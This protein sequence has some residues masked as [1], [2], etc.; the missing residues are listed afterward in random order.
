MKPQSCSFWLRKSGVPLF[1]WCQRRQRLPPTSLK[2]RHS[3]SCDGCHKTAAQTTSCSENG[4]DDPWFMSPVLLPLSYEA[5]KLQLLATEIWC[6]TVYVVPEETAF[7]TYKPRARVEIRHSFSRDGC[8][9]TAAQSTG[10]SENC[11]HDPWFT[12][13][14]LLT[15]C[16]EDTRLQLLSTK[17]GCS[18]VYAIPEERAFA[19][20]KPRARVEIRQSCSGDGCRKTAGQ[21]TGSSENCTHDPW[22][23]RPVL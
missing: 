13:P 3:F 23:T 2:I 5:T 21:S 6:S 16:S 18:T 14:V 8:R 15:R 17:I 22:F 1:M 9:K 20:Y 10:S 11:T 12:R 7:A 4:R 19:T